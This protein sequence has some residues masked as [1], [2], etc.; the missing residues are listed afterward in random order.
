MKR[1]AEKHP[2]SEL[3][4]LCRRLGGGFAAVLVLSSLARAQAVV[5]TPTWT[6]ASSPDETVLSGIQDG[7]MAGRRSQVSVVSPGGGTTFTM[8]YAATVFE[9]NELYALSCPARHEILDTDYTLTFTATAPRIY[10]LILD[11]R[12]SGDANVRNDAIPAEH[13]GQADQ[14]PVTCAWTGGTLVGGGCDLADPGPAILGGDVNQPYDQSNSLTLCAT[15]DGAAVP[16]T[17]QFLWTQRAYS[18]AVNL[19][20]EQQG[21]DA[22]VRLGDWVSVGS[23]SAPIYPGA[24][25]RTQ[26]DDGHFTTA[27][28]VDLCGNGVIDACGADVEACDEGAANGSPASCCTDDCR[29]KSAGAPCRPSADTCDVPEACTGSSPLCPADVVVPAGSTCRPS[30]GP[31][32]VTDVC[33]GVGPLCGDVKVP[34]GTVCRPQYDACDQ[35]DVCNGMSALCVDALR[36]SGTVC[37]G[38]QGDGSC[39]IVEQCTGA[40]PLCPPDAIKPAASICRPEAGT[41]DVAEACDGTSPSCAA[42]QVLPS[43]AVCNPSSGPCDPQEVCDGNAGVCPDDVDL[44]D[45]DND[46]VCGPSDNCPD[47]PNPSQQDG[48]GDDVGDACDPCIGEATIQDSRLVMRFLNPPGGNDRL[49]FKGLLAGV[50][51]GPAIDPLANGARVVLADAAGNRIVDAALAPGAFD[52]ILGLGWEQQGA[53]FDYAHFGAVGPP[54][55]HIIRARI[56]LLPPDAVRVR[57]IGRFGTYPVAGLPVRMTMV[58]NGTAVGASQCADETFQN[59]PDG[60]PERCDPITGGGTL[61]C[62]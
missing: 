57:V 60:N 50:V 7:C 53:V 10:N 32:D 61:R 49:K 39:D 31:C 29:L 20:L 9:D 13:D 27:T 62:R 6:N 45:V 3:P 55:G 18:G 14:G 42:D 43:G 4:G 15:S 37:R 21:D 48:D 5:S 19:I 30:A 23:A 38:P 52:P 51:P 11:T 12:R 56:K 17:L 22:A 25:A 35:T 41:C 33:D 34:A 8:R 2:D 36:P 54:P 58:V 47:T 40:S 24:P 28:L 44:T 59:V 1:Q 46:L 16:H 26:S